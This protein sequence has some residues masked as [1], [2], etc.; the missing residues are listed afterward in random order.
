M[1]IKSLYDVHNGRA[2]KKDK[3]YEAKKAQKGWFILVDE[4][5]EEYGY[6]PKLFEVVEDDKEEK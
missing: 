5:G 2:L 6:P 3:I 4:S 1:R